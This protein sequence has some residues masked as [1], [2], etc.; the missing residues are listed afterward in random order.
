[1]NLEESYNRLKVDPNASTEEIKKVYRKLAKTYHPDINPQGKEKFT[2]IN[3]AYNFIIECR[4]KG[5]YTQSQTSS[6]NQ[7]TKNNPYYKTTNK[8]K[9]YKTSYNSNHGYD[10]STGQTLW[11]EIYTNSRRNNNFNTTF[12]FQY[13]AKGPN[14]YI[15]YRLTKEDINKG[16]NTQFIN[17]Q[18]YYIKR[19]ICPSCSGTGKESKTC[20]KCGGSGID[21]TP[22]NHV[23]VNCK[24]C[25]G[26]GVIDSPSICSK[27]VGKGYININT[28]VR[29]RVPTNISEDF[30]ITLPGKGDEVQ[31][32]PLDKGFFISGDLVIRIIPYSDASYKDNDKRKEEYT[33]KKP[34]NKKKIEDLG[35]IRIS[36]MELI[37]GKEQIIQRGQEPSIRVYIKPN[38]ELGKKEIKDKNGNVYKFQLELRNINYKVLNDNHM[39]MINYLSKSNII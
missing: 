7:Y 28:Y 4:D 23:I 6:S 30:F 32:N 21:R 3:E 15:D 35:I 39:D 14:K 29:V 24:Y 2:M 9:S 38:S 1:M 17:K 8:K 33:K 5:I 27:C 16:R 34:R 22:T 13:Q 18:I 36:L 31:L 25:G 37:K 20:D 19:T 12:D 26:Q 11:E 10:V